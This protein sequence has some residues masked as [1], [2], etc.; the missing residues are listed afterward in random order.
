MDRVKHFKVRVSLGD[1]QKDSERSSYMRREQRWRTSEEAKQKGTCSKG[2]VWAPS[3]GHG[4][5]V[6][7]CSDEQGAGRPSSVRRSLGQAVCMEMGMMGLG[8]GGA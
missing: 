2:S 7:S 8:L 1:K 6:L 4:V 3:R 5:R